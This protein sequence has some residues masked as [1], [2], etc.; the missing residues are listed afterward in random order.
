WTIMFD[1]FVLSL[2]MISTRWFDESEFWLALVKLVTVVAFILLGRLAIFGVLGYQGYEAAPLF[3]N[4][5]AQGWFPEGLF[6]SSATMLIVNFAI[7]GTEMTGVAAGQPEDPADN[8]PTVIN[9]AI[10]RLLIF[11]VC[12]IIVVTALL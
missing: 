8:V 3:T 11:F 10:F 2:N 7:S 6:P 1:V 9:T 5:T 4:L 12:T